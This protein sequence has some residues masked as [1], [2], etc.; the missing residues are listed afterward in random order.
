M[1]TT[2]S[3]LTAALL[4]TGASSAF[5]ASTDLTVKG[6]ITPSAC[7]PNL[8]NGGV[9][10]YAK[11][12]AS[13]L[14][15]ITDTPI[16]TQT[17]QVTVNCDAS[18]LFAI[19][20]IDNRIGTASTAAN[21]YFGLGLINETE[22]LGGYSL[23]FQDPIAES[24]VNTLHSQD[25]GA[26]WSR[27]KAGLFAPG[28]WMGFGSETAGGWAPDALQNLTANLVVDAFIA[29]TDSL[30]LTDEVKLDGSVTLQ[31]EYL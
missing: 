2:V 16:G 29:R 31:I 12:S 3:L 27:S 13:D 4:I 26:T 23:R 22:K 20:A 9:V 24:P 14:N 30:T 28:Y 21:V 7:T 19:S 10:D 11:I 5:A 6:L 15:Q 25:D 18:A 1:K 8:A 17:L